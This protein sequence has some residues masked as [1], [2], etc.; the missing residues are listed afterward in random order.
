MRRFVVITMIFLLLAGCS[1]FPVSIPLLQSP[2][3]VPV[4]SPQPTATPFAL[5]ASNTPDLFVINTLASS[6][7]QPAQGPLF[8]NTPNPT[9]TA[10]IRPTITLEPLD[11]NLFTPSPNMFVSVQRST[12]QIV[13]GSK[14]DGARS[15]K[16]VVQT[17]PSP[18]LKY[19]LLFLRLQ[20]KYSAH[21]T[22]WGAGAIL[23]DND[24]GVYFYTIELDQINDYRTFEDAWMQYQFVAL[25]K[26]RVVMG[27][28]VVSRTDVSVTHCKTINP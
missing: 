23:S 13:W 28:S 18:K 21:R 26:F 20:D 5:P 22:D 27:R 9:S 4:N 15:I 8:T 10:T 24:Q 7:Q 19:V 25:T 3:P 11:P 2:T 14:C 16:F 12:S 17:V 1:A 6:S